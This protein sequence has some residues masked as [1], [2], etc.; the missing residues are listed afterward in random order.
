MSLVGWVLIDRDLWAP[1]AIVSGAEQ[2]ARPLSTDRQ[3]FTDLDPRRPVDAHM[4]DDGGD[5][6]V[7]PRELAASGGASGGKVGQPFQSWSQPAAAA[8]NVATG[9]WAD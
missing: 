9:E 8:R 1:V 7:D 5:L 3:S 4:G 2:L 6:F